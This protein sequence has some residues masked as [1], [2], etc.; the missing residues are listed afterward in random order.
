M[1]CAK[2]AD[3]EEAAQDVFISDNHERWTI[4]LT[5]ARG[6]IIIRD[7]ATLLIN[8]RSTRGKRIA[9]ISLMTSSIAPDVA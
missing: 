5:Q 8:S 9:K 6:C 4:D 1:W 2:S 7:G 3:N